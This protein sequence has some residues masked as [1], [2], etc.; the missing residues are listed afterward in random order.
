MPAAS[1]LIAPG[2]ATITAFWTAWVIA[3][4]VTGIAV[5]FFF[6]GLED[7][8]VSSFNAVLW[9]GLLAGVFGVTGGSMWLW[10]TN[11]PVLAMIVAMVLG[12]PGLLAGLFMLIVAISPPRWN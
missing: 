8:S 3:A 11:H 4:I 2:M 6:V 12:I 10:K 1:G 5:Y 9:A 7:G